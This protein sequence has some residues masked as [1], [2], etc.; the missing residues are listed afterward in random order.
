MIITFLEASSC[1]FNILALFGPWL[2]LLEIPDQFSLV[3]WDYL[4]SKTGRGG[5]G[6]VA[7]ACVILRANTG[8][9]NFAR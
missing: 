7:W 1:G 9:W 4:G 5:G 6:E 2:F 8:Y 3:I